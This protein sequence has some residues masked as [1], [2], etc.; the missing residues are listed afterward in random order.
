MVKADDHDR[1]P[2]GGVT[3]GCTIWIMAARYGRLQG[4]CPDPDASRYCMRVCGNAESYSEILEVA[5]R[6][7]ADSGR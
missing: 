1:V 4:R 3:M 2:N 5:K 7:R 6:R